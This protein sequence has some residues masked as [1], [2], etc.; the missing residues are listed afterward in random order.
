MGLL[1]LEAT[2][3]LTQ[4][5]DMGGMTL[6]VTHNGFNELSR[7]EMLWMVRHHWPAGGRFSFRCYK[8]WA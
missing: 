5:S 7:L 4:K 8:H 2:G 1:E 6:V 3:F